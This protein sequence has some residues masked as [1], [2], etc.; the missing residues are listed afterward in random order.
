M[1][2]ETFFPVPPVPVALVEQETS[3]QPRGV[4]VP[5]LITMHKAT[6]A[7]FASNPKK[8]ASMD[9]LTFKVWQELWPVVQTR[10]LALYQ[11]SYQLSYIPKSWKVAKII[12]LQKPGKLDYTKPKAFRPISLL[13]TISKGLEAVI[14]A[15]LS[16]LAE[17]HSLLLK[18]HFGARPKCLVK[19]AL[20]V[21]VER[22]YETWRGKRKVLLVSFNVWGVFNSVHSSALYRRLV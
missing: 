9:G 1:L 7:I 13:L 3:R 11:A 16:Y 21:L 22:I 5:H 15:R 4:K 6:K 10:V 20:V 2:I 14:A 17:E 8:A 12:T 18:N 19:Q